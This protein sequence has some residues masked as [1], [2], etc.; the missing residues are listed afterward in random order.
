MN[1]ETNCKKTIMLFDTFCTNMQYPVDLHDKEKIYFM[2]A[3]V[4][5]KKQVCGQLMQTIMGSCIDIVDYPGSNAKS[6]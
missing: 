4:N 1:A 6:N 3:D 2:N 5:T